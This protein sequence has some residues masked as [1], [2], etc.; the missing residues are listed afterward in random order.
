MMDRV[1]TAKLAEEKGFVNK[2][3]P[4]LKD[5]PDFFDLSKVPAIG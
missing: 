3:L 1:V 2:V 5:E 4:A